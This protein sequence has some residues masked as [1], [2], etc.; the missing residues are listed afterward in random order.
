MQGHKYSQICNLWGKFLPVGMIRTTTHTISIPLVV[1]Y[2]HAR[3]FCALAHTS[4]IPMG[5]MNFYL[6]EHFLQSLIPLLFPCL[7]C[8]YMLLFPSSMGAINFYM[9]K[10]FLHEQIFTV[11]TEVR[12]RANRAMAT[13]NSTVIIKVMLVEVVLI[14]GF[15]YR[16]N[17]QLPQRNR[18]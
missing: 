15:L 1:M 13:N 3:M 9:N 16:A 4:S 18:F 14:E 11:I 17:A 6:Q 8:I 7:R 10:H 2:L 5:A 12:P